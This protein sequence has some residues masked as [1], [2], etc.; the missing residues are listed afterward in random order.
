MS[1]KNTKEHPELLEEKCKGC[2]RVVEDTDLCDTCNECAN[3]SQPHRCCECEEEEYCECSFPKFIIEDG[4][5]SCSKCGKDDHY[6]CGVVA[7]HS[8]EE[9]EEEEEED[10]CDICIV[11]IEKYDYKNTGKMCL[12]HDP[13]DLRGE[14]EEEEEEISNEWFRLEKWMIKQMK[15]IQD[16]VL[17]SD[18]AKLIL[19]LMDQNQSNSFVVKAFDKFLKEQEKEGN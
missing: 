5:Q 13:R 3:P 14:E 10:P 15:L 7:D 11:C 16:G 8:E 6:K 18:K 19:D 4:I 17:V 2:E 1:N 9:E 12:I